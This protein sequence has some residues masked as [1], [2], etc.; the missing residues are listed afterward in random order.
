MP[1]Q[2]LF[3]VMSAQATSALVNGA[4]QGGGTQTAGYGSAESGPAE[5]PAAVRPQERSGAEQSEQT[6]VPPTTSDVNG[7][8]VPSSSNHLEGAGRATEGVLPA[9]SGESGTRDGF[10]ELQSG[11]R[12]SAQRA[13]TATGLLDAMTSPGLP[14]VGE[15]PGEFGVNRGFFTPRS[16][17]SQLGGPS[18]AGS[19]YWPGWMTRIGELF[20]QPTAPAWMPS[21]IPSPPRPPT[22]LARRS[23]DL[24][25]AD[26]EGLLGFRLGGRTFATPPSSSV[27]AEAIQAEVQRQLGSLLDRLSVAEAENAKLQ[28]ALLRER[29]LAQGQGQMI[30][31]SSTGRD[32]PAQDVRHVVSGHSTVSAGNP[33]HV[34]PAQEAPPRDPPRRAPGQG[35]SGDP[36]SAIWEGISGKFGSRARTSGSNVVVPTVPAAPKMPASSIDAP[37]TTSSQPPTGVPNEITHALTQGMQQLQDLQLKAMKKDNDSGDSPEVVKTAKVNL[38][39]L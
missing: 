20:A 15:D 36:W 13:E 23:L 9:S 6:A 27:P 7:P 24:R 2:P 32:Q 14:D 25:T 19:G 1:G 22:Q 31:E 29:S 35:S 33:V 30:H 18:T 37:A 4:P 26:D 38:P 3:E 5:P 10:P 21:P 8:E 11:M 12:S 17:T 28:D 39:E 34:P 16:R